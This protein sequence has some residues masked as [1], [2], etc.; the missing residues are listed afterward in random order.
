MNKKALKGKQDLKKN[1]FYFLLLYLFYEHAC[2]ACMYAM[3]LLV[4]LRGR[5][6]H[7]MF[8]KWVQT[9]V[10]FHVDAGTLHH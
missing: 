7:K 4:F 5:R 6:K 1:Y 9:M 3:C 10:S 8:C 2:F